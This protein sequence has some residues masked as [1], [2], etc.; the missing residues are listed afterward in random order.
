MHTN[1]FLMRKAIEL[2]EDQISPNTNNTALHMN[3]RVLENADNMMFTKF[4]HS[5]PIY[6]TTEKS[7]I[8]VWTN[9]QQRY[10]KEH[11]EGQ[12]MKTSCIVNMW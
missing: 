3:K 12:S 7:Q 5:V 11:D 4:V 10:N 1:N 8:L 6:E 2:K 9:R